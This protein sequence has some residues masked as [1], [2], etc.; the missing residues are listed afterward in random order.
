MTCCTLGASVPKRDWDMHPAAKEWIEIR[1]CGRGSFSKV[2]LAK[3]AYDDGRQAAL[4]IV[5]VDDADLDGSTA[6]LLVAEGELLLELDH[7]NIV[8]CRCVLPSP[9]LVIF[10]LEYLHGCSLLD[11]I[12]KMRHTY[13]EKDASRIFSQVASAVSYMHAH[14]IMHRDIKPENIVFTEEIEKGKPIPPV[15]LI[16]L[17]LSVRFSASKRVR[18]CLGSAGFVAPEIID[19]GYHTPSMDVFGM[20]VLLFVM[21]VGRKPWD[22]DQCEKLKYHTIPLKEAP[23]L[24][25]PRWLDLSPDA[26]HL[27]IGMLQYDPE[28]RLTAKEVLR[29]EWIQTEGGLTIRHLGTSIA[30]GAATVA[31]MRRLRYISQ[32]IAAVDGHGMHSHGKHKEMYLDAL[33]RS[34][35]KEK[36]VHGRT[37]AKS[38]A[39]TIAARS[40]AMAHDAG[41]SVHEKV[42][43]GSQYGMRRVADSSSVTEGNLDRSVSSFKLV[44]SAMKHY[45]EERSVHKGSSRHGPGSNVIHEKRKVNIIKHME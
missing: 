18:G 41:R 37:W 2:V 25:D 19:G 17:G 11:G 21:L 30:E 38:V 26:K 34:V 24:R 1:E 16:D 39:H 5:F 8:K 6:A 14:G 43:E 7:P 40:F 42:L 36:S 29:H 32:G 31:E 22:L 13:S 33:D 28:K 35:R 3:H 27:L 10:E 12:Y 44:S 23:G 15:K 9:T 45:M 20:G 4:K